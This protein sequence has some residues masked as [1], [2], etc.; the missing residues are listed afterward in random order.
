MTIVRPAAGVYALGAG[1][2]LGGVREF[3]IART[4]ERTLRHLAR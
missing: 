4:P 2:F 3:M 1:A